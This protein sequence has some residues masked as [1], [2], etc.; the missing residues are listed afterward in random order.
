MAEPFPAR[1]V[2]VS[3]RA[4][5][6]RVRTLERVELPTAPAPR[7]RPGGVYLVV[8]G[9]GAVG[10]DTCRH[11]ARDYGAKLVVV[12]RSPLDESRR[13]VVAELEKE[14]AE[15]RYLALDATGPDALKEAV[16]IAVQEFGSLHGVINA[17]MV[18]VNQVL[19]ELP[20]D[21]LRTALESRTDTTWTLLQAV[22]DVPL[23]FALLYSS[24]VTFEGNHGQAGYA[25]GCAFADACALH[26]AR[27]LPFPVRVLNLGYW[28]AG[29]DPEREGVLRR[30]RAAGIRPLSAEQG[31]TVVERTLAAGL[32]QVFAL[33][34]DRSILDNLGIDPDRTLSVLPGGAP[35]PLPEVRFPGEAGAHRELAAHQRAAAEAE[36]LA[37]RLLASVLDRAG[38]FGVGEA[39]REE[40]GAR[41]AVVPEHAALFQAQ[42]DMLAEAGWLTVTDT[43]RIRPTGRRTTPE[44]ELLAEAGRL[45]E[46]HPP[47]APVV[48][49]VGACLTAL[50]DVLTGRRPAMEVLFPEGST[51]QVAAVYR[52]DPVTD[53][54]NGEVARLVAEQVRARRVAD[55]TAP[56]R[57]LEVG[58]GTGGTTAAVLSALAASG[59]GV[60]Y[61]F[62][63]VSPAFV[64]KARNRF[65]A[66]YPFTRFEVL[67]IE[68]DPAGQGPAS[69]AHDVVLATN[70]LHAT[71]RLSDTLTGVKRLLRRGGALLLVE[72]T[73]ARHQWALVFGL[74]SGW[75]LFS[76]PEQRM[77]RSPLASERQWRDVLAACGFTDISAAAPT[78]EA[79][80]AFQ[81]VLAAVSDGVVP[82]DGQVP[83]ARRVPRPTP[84][85][86]P[87]PASAAAPVAPV[88]P[89]SQD[90]PLRQVTNVFARVLEMAP[91]Q[92][93]P[94]LTFENYGVDSLVVLE[95]TRALEAVYG[96]QPATLLFER[97]T[98]RQLAG[99]FG[100]PAH[101]PAAPGTAT[102]TV[103]TTRPTAPAGHGPAATGDA[104]RLV[105]GLSDAAVD[106]LLAELLS[107][108]GESEGGGR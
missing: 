26:A 87:A 50:L 79:G 73:R 6:R 55:P 61:V 37:L 89:A 93:D 18:L 20:E 49:L 7:F 85:P 30:F 21:G 60:E 32:P 67:D 47:L 94:D 45:A 24:G 97:I 46:R 76:D 22:R 95:L 16:D 99:H 59:D 107:Q 31:M 70:V 65:G 54:C 63:D 57:I 108:R 90:D 102:T 8:G 27:T 25:A 23:D 84:A 48:G 53:R 43:G 64:R 56:V 44:G 14:G 41:L 77:P 28:H 13:Q 78:T 101:G 1:P 98:I 72:G 9:L 86:A 58:A 4:G 106:E 81:S 96:P 38:L 66:Q 3:L 51:E 74:T 11:L 19:R 92:L 10:R 39:S 100:A 104:E 52:G 17:A 71:R 88:S 80:P 2:P 15:V 103:A 36:E 12:G 68:A 105:A 42:L 82:G 5:V 29:G 69:G 40:L 83:G 35:V 75:W 33:D 34:A 62:T 91:D